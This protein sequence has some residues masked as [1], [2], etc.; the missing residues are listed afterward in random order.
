MDHD[1]KVLFQHDPGGAHQDA[2]YVVRLPDG[3]W[4]LLFGNAGAHCLT[5]D[6]TELWHHPLREAQHVVVGRFRTDSPCQ[7]MVIDRGQPRDGGDRAPAVL[8]LYGLDGREIWRR[9]QPAGSWACAIVGI[10]WLGGGAPEC[11]L[12]YSRGPGQPAAIYDGDGNIVDTFI[13]QSTPDRTDADRQAHYYGS[14]A[15]VWGDARDEVILF[16]SRG[17][18]IYSNARPLAIPTLYNNNLYPGM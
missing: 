12:T 8:Y 15:D 13:M 2:S 10:D 3:T 11:V 6:G 14:R 9:E 17:A 4:R 5:V 1:G 16:G 7:A 18:C